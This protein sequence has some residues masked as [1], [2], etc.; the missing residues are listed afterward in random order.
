MTFA[1][2][3]GRYPE[4]PGCYLMLD[5][6]GRVLY[7]G[8]AINLRSRLSSYFRGRPEKTKTALLV[9]EIRDIDIMIV[10]NENE[11]LTLERELIKQYRPPFNRAMRS[12][13]SVLPYIAV[14]SET[15]PR[16]T[17]VDIARF[18]TAESHAAAVQ[19]QAGSLI[20]PFPNVPYRDIVLDYVVDTFRLPGDAP[21][22]ERFAS[23][24]YRELLGSAAEGRFTPDR[25]A[26]SMELAIRLLHNPDALLQHMDKTM[27]DYAEQLHFERAL[28]IK[29]H[30]DAL[31][32][33][34]EK[35]SVNRPGS[36]PETVVWIGVAHALSAHLEDGTLRRRFDF[37]ALP[38]EPGPAGA[39]VKLLAAIWSQHRPHEIIT[40]AGELGQE[41]AAELAARCPG[42]RLC[43]PLRGRKRSL[44]HI[45]RINLEYRIS[46]LAENKD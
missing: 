6:S 34:Q 40:N 25:L 38:Q 35:Q 29:K 7:V 24:F 3:S 30:R 12:G 44:L 9:R 43:T 14:S 31:V 17:G 41:V 18:Q 4:A 36:K 8:K 20:G 46:L 45:C 5:E 26:Q 27:N 21:M 33:M 1:F 42:I 37:D 11:S 28:Q 23:R 10:T 15:L 16:L 39:A 32:R 22:D 13:P 19:E 2:R